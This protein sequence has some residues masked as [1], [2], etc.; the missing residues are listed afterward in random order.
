MLPR[1][2]PL[3]QIAVELEKIATK[4]CSVDLP[5]LFVATLLTHCALICLL[6]RLR[7]PPQWLRSSTTHESWDPLSP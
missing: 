6:R 2:D 7:L 4:A 1:E 3:L 5:F